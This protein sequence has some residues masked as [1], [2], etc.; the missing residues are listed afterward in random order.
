MLL[1][2][3][4]FA[5]SLTPLE[6]QIIMAGPE[7]MLR[8]VMDPGMEQGLRS[9]FTKIEET[10]ADDIFPAY[11]DTFPGI[12]LDECVFIILKV[13]L[14]SALGSGDEYGIEMGFDILDFFEEIDSIEDISHLPDDILEYMESSYYQDCISF[15]RIFDPETFLQERFPDY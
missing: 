3:W 7:E 8:M 9:L 5:Q 2:G 14:I 13:A 6:R 10:E 15:Y 4:L 12:T 11:M 1:G